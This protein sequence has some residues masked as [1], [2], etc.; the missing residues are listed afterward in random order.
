MQPGLLDLDF[1]K[2]LEFRHD[3]YNKSLSLGKSLNFILP[4]EQWCKTSLGKK[5]KE[6]EVFSRFQKIVAFKIKIQFTLDI[7]NRSSGP[8]IIVIDKFHF[9]HQHTSKYFYKYRLKIG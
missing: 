5:Q 1:C 3:I 7:H 4:L 8:V 2:I 6:I 9:P